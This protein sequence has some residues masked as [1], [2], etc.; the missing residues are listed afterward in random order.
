MRFRRQEHVDKITVFDDNDFAGEP[1]SR[2]RTKGLVA[3]I[4]KHT[5]Q[6]GSTQCLT[7]LSVGEA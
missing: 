4:E 1:D 2:K 6:S 3:R 7:A 5:V